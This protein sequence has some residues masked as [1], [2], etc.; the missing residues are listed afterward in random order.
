MRRILM[1]GLLTKAQPLQRW[2]RTTRH[3]G[4]STQEGAQSSRPPLKW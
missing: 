3:L 4:I 1:S 2:V